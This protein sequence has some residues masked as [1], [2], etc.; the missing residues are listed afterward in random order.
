MFFSEEQVSY[1]TTQFMPRLKDESKSAMLDVV[2]HG[3]SILGSAQKHKITHQSLSKNLVKLKELQ[4]KIANASDLFPSSYL[5][6]QNAGALLMAETS[7]SDAK[8]L[9]V[10]LCEKLGGKVES[11]N[12]GKE[13]RL[14][15]DKKVTCVFLNPNDNYEREWSYDH[16]DAE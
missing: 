16:H 7:F 3:L 1:L 4:S 15:L 14:N 10:E 8:R 2:C 9:L 12:S 5:L 11:V 13:V 6:E